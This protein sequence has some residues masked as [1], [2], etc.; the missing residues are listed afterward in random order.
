MS[1]GHCIY[2]LALL[3]SSWSYLCFHLIVFMNGLFI[4][5]FKSGMVC[6]PAI[7]A[8]HMS[9]QVSA[10]TGITSYFYI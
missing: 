1:S 10:T 2:N 6:I 9:P 3:F 4:D 5:Y 7:K 8:S